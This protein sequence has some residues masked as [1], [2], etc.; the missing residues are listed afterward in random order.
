MKR[1]PNC[2]SYN[3]ARAH[4]NC[5][6][7]M[8]A[9]EVALIDLLTLL[10]CTRISYLVSLYLIDLSSRLVFSA[11]TFS[12]GTCLFSALLE[13]SPDNCQWRKPNVYFITNN[14]IDICFFCTVWSIVG[15]MRSSL[16]MIMRLSWSVINL[17]CWLWLNRVI[18]EIDSGDKFIIWVNILSGYNIVNLFNTKKNQE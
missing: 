18:T 4:F 5:H 16:L 9:T 6:N 15:T 13:I 11:V 7:W 8:I 3:D 12:T 1:Q 2:F 14:L 10:C 17:L